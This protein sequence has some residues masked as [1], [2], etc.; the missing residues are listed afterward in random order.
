MQKTRRASGL[1]EDIVEGAFAGAMSKRRYEIGS[2]NVFQ[3]IGVPNEEEH[4]VKAQLVFKIDAI[5]KERRLR[6]VEIAELLG[7]RQVLRAEFA[8]RAR[9]G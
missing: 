3:D 2:R 7:I 6:Q 5:V 1:D 9:V 8:D 4:L